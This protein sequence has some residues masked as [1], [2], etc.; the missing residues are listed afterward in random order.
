MARAECSLLYLTEEVVRVAI[1]FELPKIPN[2]HQLL[3]PDLGGIED[4][5]IEVVLVSFWDDLYAKLPL[6][7]CSILNGFPQI[8]PVEIWILASKLQSFVP[9]KGMYSE[10]R[11]ENELNKRP[12]TLAID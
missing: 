11:C 6:R 1:E 2:W 5:K 9:D 12:F 3:R 7:R 8:S 10:L 4:I